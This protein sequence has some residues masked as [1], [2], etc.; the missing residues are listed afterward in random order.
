MDCPGLPWRGRITVAGA[1]LTRAASAA[2]TAFL[3]AAAPG[4]FTRDAANLT[5]GYA[6]APDDYTF[7][8]M[9]LHEANLCALAGGVDLFLLGSELRGLET[10]RGPGWTKAGT[11]DA[12]GAAAWDYPFVAGL[13]QLADDV[14]GVFDAA[15]LARDTTRLTN[16]VSYASDWSSWMGWQHPGANGQWPH[17]DALYARPSIDL[18]AF[19]NYLPLSDWTT[20]GGGLDAQRWSAPPPGGLGLLGTPALLTKAYIKANI[21]GGEKYDW[22]Y[23]DSTNDGP[24]ADPAGSALVVSRPQGDR[25]AQTRSAYAPGQELLANKMLRWWWHNPHHAIYDSGDGRG[26]VAQGP[27]TAW[28]PIA[29]SICF[30]EYGVPSCDRGTNQPNVFYDPRSS[31][32]FTAFWSA[33]DPAFGGG[34]EPRRDTDLQLLA[35]QAFY[36]YWFVD[37]HNEVSAAGLPMIE[38]T[39]TSVWNWDARPFPAFPARD[40][41]WGD[42]GNWRAGQWLNGK[43]PTFALPQEDSAPPPASYPVFPTLAGQAA[44]MTLRPRFIGAATVHVSGRAARISRADQPLWDVELAFDLLRMT[45]NAPEMQTLLAFFDA[46][47]GRAQTLLVPSPLPAVADGALGTGDGT[48]TVFPLVRAVGGYDVSVIAVDGTPRVAVDGVSATADAFTVAR[49]PMLA[50]VFQIPPAAGAVLTASFAD[51]FACR[52]ADDQQSL[53]AFAAGLFSTGTLVLQGVRA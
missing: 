19:D 24:G 12:S 45:Q 16:L 2:V 21:E 30:T 20:G 15:G 42:A 8:R 7:R 39:F 51:F 53:E 49:N 9:I 1:D 28:T 31:E 18:V 47:R 26:W 22:F 43:A 34:V 13:A 37:G 3:G 46:C 40:D 4:D 32:S 33:W 27:A 35:L 52:F 5:V 14:R 50:I 6:G 38:P 36:E 29:K 10:V 25:L 11:T 44:T 41:V 48:Q 17:L 23:A